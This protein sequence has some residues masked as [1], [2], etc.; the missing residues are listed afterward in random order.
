[1]TPVGSLR[2]GAGNANVAQV[3][4][5][6]RSY[7]RAVDEAGLLN[8][9]GD[10]DP[11]NQGRY[12]ALIHARPAIFRP[13]CYAM[14]VQARAAFPSSV[15]KYVTHKIL[16]E[17]RSGFCRAAPLYVQGDGSLDLNALVHDHPDVFTP[18]C[19]IAGLAGYTAAQFPTLTRT[20]YALKLKRFCKL[21]MERRIITPVP[22]S[23]GR[24]FQVH[25]GPA[26]R[27]LLREVFA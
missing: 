7:C 3:R 22:G 6:V 8:D 9:A 13:L 12:V 20:E 23:F 21:A 16:R 4:D 24:D 26:Y 17:Y 15:R 19:Y 25:K 18:F 1:M 10:L 27:A 14:T 2:V 11:A 5:G